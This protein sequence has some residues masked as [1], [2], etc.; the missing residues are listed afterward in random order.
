VKMNFDQ[1]S[2]AVETAVKDE[3]GQTM[4]EYGV[5]LSLIA[6][7]TVGTYTFLGDQVEALVRAAAGLLT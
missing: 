2:E 6:I 4:A 3:R 5:V 7:V 1:I